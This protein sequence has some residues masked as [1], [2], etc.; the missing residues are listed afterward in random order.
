VLDDKERMISD[1]IVAFLAG[2]EKA[3][4]RLSTRRRV[5]G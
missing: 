3:F 5:F 2:Y 1:A 4:G